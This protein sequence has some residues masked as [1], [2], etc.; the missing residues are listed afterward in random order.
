MLQTFCGTQIAA[1]LSPR[2]PAPPG[3]PVIGT[4]QKKKQAVCDVPRSEHAAVCA[5][6]GCKRDPESAKLMKVYGGFPQS[7]RPSASTVVYLKP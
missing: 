7:L 6:L 3:R 5:V 2:K 4:T 1:G